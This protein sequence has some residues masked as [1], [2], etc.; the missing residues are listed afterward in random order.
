MFDIFQTNKKNYFKSLMVLLT[1][2]ALTFSAFRERPNT[3]LTLADSLKVGAFVESDFPFISTSINAG[4]LGSGF[5]KENFAA[6]TLAIK[7]GDSAYFCFDTNLLRWSVAWTRDFIPMAL[8]PQV[9][10]SDFFNKGN[11]LATIGGV[12]QIATRNRAGW[13]KVSSKDVVNSQSDDF[14][15]WAPLPEKEGRWNGLYMVGKQTVLHYSVGNSKIMELPGSAAFAGQTVFSRTFRINEISEALQLIPAEVVDGNTVEIKGNIAYIYQGFSKDTVTAVAIA[16][17]RTKNGILRI[18]ESSTFVVSFPTNKE[19]SEATILVWKGPSSLKKQF[20]K[21]S[22]KTNIQ[23]P[24]FEKGGPNHWPQDIITKGEIALDTAAFVTDKLTLPIPNRWERN[25]RVADIA[26]FTDGRAAVI[27]FDGDVWTVSG[28]DSK[29]QNLKWRR[30]ASGFNESMS[31]EVV[32]DQVFVF[33]RNGITKLHDL[34]ADGMADYYENFSNI[35]EQSSEGRE[36]AADLVH[37]R[38]GGFYVAI[39]GSLSNGPGVTPVVAKGFRKGSKHNGSILKISEDGRSLEVIATGLRGPYLGYNPVKDILTVSDQQGNFVP[40][41]PLFVVKKGDFFGVPP[42]AHRTDNPKVTPTLTWIP[43]HIDQSSLG[44]AWVTGS[45]MGPLNGNLIHF[46]FGRPGLFR[47]LIDSTSKVLQGGLSAIKADYPAPTSKGALSPLDEQLYVAGFNLWGSNSKGL[48]ALLRLRYTGKPSYAPSAF[49]AGKEGIILGFDSELD[50]A[51][52]EKIT[53]FEVKRYNYVRTQEYGSGHFKTDGSKGED[54]LP[55][56]GSYLSAD[57]KK[58]LLLIP[59]MKEVMQMEIAY[60][61]VA[62]DGHKLN[63][64]FWFTVNS[65][66]ALNLSEY[67]FGKV[68]LALL[69]KPVVVTEKKVEIASVALGKKIFQRTAC[70][71]CH[72][73]GTRTKGMYGPPF[74]GLYG[75][76][77]EFDDGTSAIADDAYIRESILNPAK[78]VVKGYNSEMPSFEG[79]LTDND[80][81]SVT[82]FIKSLTGK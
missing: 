58:L 70:A 17:K 21:L 16:G 48:S 66:D 65:A 46:S 80:I 15:Q 79:I 50:A 54:K 69:T 40:S 42:T 6:R 47:V 7:L 31:I 10:Y 26:F 73:E 45:K 11:K 72:S 2:I 55:V 1:V 76:K 8:M 13:S 41:S 9:S 62:K 28:I 12:P 38:D 67:G 53:S 32:K 75:S 39:G 49:H 82:L 43:H 20:E 14:D 81:I 34:N 19:V 61:L 37:A 35:M 77:R 59:D 3:V 51:S 60:D 52:A 29:L 24:N 27:T 44:Q 63:D 23:F 56:V 57:R 74:Q 22:K 4:K 78:H 36:W 33:D 64:Q 18:D 68:D 5:P 30:Y 25:V 71:G